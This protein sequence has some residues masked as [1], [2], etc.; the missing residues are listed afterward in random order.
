MIDHKIMGDVLTLVQTFGLPLVLL[1]ILGVAY[2]RLQDQHEVDRKEWTAKLEAERDKCASERREW[3]EERDARLEHE[4]LVGEKFQQGQLDMNRAMLEA[5]NKTA[6]MAAAFEQEK[7]E[8][9]EAR[10]REL[11]DTGQH[12]P[13]GRAP[14]GGERR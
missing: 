13:V 9:R 11:R 1:I 12:R 2:K 7:R 8:I 5:I 3:N 4:R 14:P 10:E 6:N